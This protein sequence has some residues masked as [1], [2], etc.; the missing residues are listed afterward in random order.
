M[1]R[2]YDL[3]TAKLSRTGEAPGMRRDQNNQPSLDLSRLIVKTEEFLTYLLVSS[4]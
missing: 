3:E 2:L 1:S 4:K